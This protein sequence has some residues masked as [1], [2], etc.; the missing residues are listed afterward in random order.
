MKGLMTFMLSMTLAFGTVCCDAAHQSAKQDGG[1]KKDERKE[2]ADKSLKVMTFSSDEKPPLFIVVNQEDSA[3]ED[4]RITVFSRLTGNILQ[5]GYSK[6]FGELAAGGMLT[7]RAEELISERGTKLS[8]DGVKIAVTGVF[9]KVRG[10]QKG[11]MGETH[12]Q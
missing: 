9:G 7:V 10:Q 5:P 1:E 2:E 4:G 3:I 6:Q 11:Y 8:D 12:K